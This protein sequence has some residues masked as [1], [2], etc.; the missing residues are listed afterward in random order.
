MDATISEYGNVT[1]VELNG[2]LDF[3]TAQPFRKT[4]LEHLVHRPLVLDLKNLNFVGSL[5]ITDFIETIEGLFEKTA[6]G[7]KLSGVSSEFRRL[8]ESSKISRLEFFESKSQALAAFNSNQS[9]F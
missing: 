5:G 3:E 8:F 6:P 9:S 7:V 2:R 1:V 4:C